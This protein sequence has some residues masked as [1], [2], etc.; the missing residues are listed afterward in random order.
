VAV[1]VQNPRKGGY[2]GIQVAGPVFYK[3]MNFA[4]RTMKIPPDHAKRPN[5][6]LTAP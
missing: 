4:L 2:F 6:R 5:V 1:N 3:V